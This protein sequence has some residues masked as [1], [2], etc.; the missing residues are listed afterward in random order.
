MDGFPN[1][2]ETLEKI[3]RVGDAAGREGGE[4][5]RA[6]SSVIEDH[7]HKLGRIE[8][9]KVNPDKKWQIS[10][11]VR[12]KGSPKDFQIGID[13]STERSAALQLWIWCRGGRAAEPK[14]CESLNSVAKQTRMRLGAELGW[15]GGGILL[16]RI[17]IAVPNDLNESVAREPIIE[18]VE[19]TFGL[20]TE[21]H[22][23]KLAAISG[24]K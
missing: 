24:T 12:P 11:R 23:K 9:T 18:D 17:E 4:L 14:M 6:C 1:P 22:V 7:F 20:F 10:F 2:D 13:L 5:L 3:T 19:K 8:R 16:G 21:E 15:S